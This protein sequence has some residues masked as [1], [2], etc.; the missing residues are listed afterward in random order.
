MGTGRLEA[1]LAHWQIRGVTS[2][3]P[4]F[5]ALHAREPRE[6]P[7][8]PSQRPIST[9]FGHPTTRRATHDHSPCSIRDPV[10]Y[11]TRQVA[12]YLEE[13]FGSSGLRVEVVA[14]VPD[15]DVKIIHLCGPVK[16]AST[17]AGPWSRRWSGT[18]PPRCR[19][20][21][22]PRARTARGL[23]RHLPGRARA[24]V[25]P[26]GWR[27]PARLGPAHEHPGA[28]IANPRR[29]HEPIPARRS[30]ALAPSTAHR[31]YL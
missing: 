24:R 20:A 28:L 9:V 13:T 5:S 8:N 23:R 25:R 4:Y 10:G 6:N 22:V 17:W 2:E 18:A 7:T 26:H 1:T 15:L 3:D 12:S 14:Q 31:P 11:R 29:P 30:P 21:P 19:C 16:G 27:E